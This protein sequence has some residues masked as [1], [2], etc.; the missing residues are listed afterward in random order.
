MGA[1]AWL[2][3]AEAITQTEETVGAGAETAAA[4]VAVTSVDLSDKPVSH[5]VHG[6]PVICR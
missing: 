2:A 1:G 6:K 4:A 3:A 5:L